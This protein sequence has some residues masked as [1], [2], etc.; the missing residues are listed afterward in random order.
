M[1]G[2]S[3]LLAAALGLAGVVACAD[4]SASSAF[5]RAGEPADVGMA[6]GRQDHKARGVANASGRPRI[7]LATSGSGGDQIVAADLGSGTVLWRQ[8]DGLAARVVVARSAVVYAR[9]DGTL[10][11][12]D[13]DSGR[14]LWTRPLPAGRQRVGYAADG[15]AIYDVTALSANPREVELTRYDARGGGVSWRVRLEGV[16][17][18]P[19]ARGGLVAIPRRSQFVSLVDGENG[20]V[21]ADILSREEAALFVRALPEGIFYGS[22]G[23]FLASADTAGGARKSAGYLQ[24]K[25]PS[26]I[27]ATYERDMYRPEQADYSAIDR[28][29]ILWRVTTDGP[30]AAFTDGV[31]VAHSFRF[32]FGLNA[33]TGKLLWAYNHLRS[34]AVAAELTG[35]EVLF[36]ASDGELGALDFATGQRVW[37]A[38]VGDGTSIVRGATFDAEG[39]V[40]RGSAGATTPEPL[41][42]TLASILFD[43]D[44]R[45]IDVKIYAIG[46]LAALEGREVT[47]EL[48]RALEAPDL[49]PLVAQK[50]VEALALRRDPASIGLYAE[51]LR[52][53]SDYAED[54]HAP[55]LDVLAKAVTATKARQALPA[56]LEHL[57]LPDTDRDA[58]RDIAD[59]VLALGAK[60]AVPAFVDF[61]LQYRADP[62]FGRD[63]AA[64]AAASEVLMKLG[65]PA[66]RSTLLFVAN[67]PRTVDQVR[68]YLQQAL[69]GPEAPK[70]EPA[71]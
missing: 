22:R 59:A 27:R 71:Q 65:G 47:S 61:L 8:T 3:P 40:P 38:R 68:A 35:Q 26:F 54:R 64:V 60:E 31:V 32:F 41:S 19:A 50:A 36:I 57:R 33:A 6:L 28:N 48:L 5:K 20:R 7:F 37:S 10:V 11:G 53:H 42:R 12:R 24:A 45:F 49:P 69:F 4:T 43:P 51:A 2:R 9:P 25:L 21:L 1:R 30:R 15:D 39:Y 16:A 29:R 44:R 17:G 52:I 56:L 67:E 34:D 55:R 58:V 23:V 70:A 46:E 13:N 62:A 63:P 66:E 18:A 14:Q